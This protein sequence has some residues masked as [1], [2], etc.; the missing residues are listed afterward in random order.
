MNCMDLK[1]QKILYYVLAGGRIN[2][3]YHRRWTFTRFANDMFHGRVKPSTCKQLDFTVASYNVLAQNLLED[4]RELYEGCGESFLKWQYR[5]Q[6][7]LRDIKKHQP[8]VSYYLFF[9]LIIYMYK[10]VFCFL[11]IYIYFCIFLYL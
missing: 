4:H 7:L 2:N 5:R 3:G 8:D 10:C 1:L 9:S 11:Y 6:N